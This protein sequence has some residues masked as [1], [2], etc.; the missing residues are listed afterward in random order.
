M[1]EERQVK[2][3]YG[4][5]YTL[6]LSGDTVVRVR[7][8]SFLSL[9]R[10]G[11]LPQ[12]VVALVLKALRG[13]VRATDDPAAALEWATL[14]DVYAVEAL[15]EPPV[16]YDEKCP[17]GNLRASDVPDNDKFLIVNWINGLALSLEEAE[18]R[19]ARGDGAALKAEIVRLEA[20]AARLLALARAQAS[21][22]QGSEPEVTAADLA[23]FRTSEGGA[24]PGDAAPGGEDLRAAAV[25]PAGDSVG[26]PASG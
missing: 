22:V 20:E 10:R 11:H 21:P 6:R 15:V 3:A 13:E 8:P 2:H 5:V 12:N 9:V 16:Y 19:A 23:T 4:R 1:A 24:E 25:E 14:L 7:R 17:E 26:A 18:E